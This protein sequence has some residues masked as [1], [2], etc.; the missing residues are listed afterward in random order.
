V[1]LGEQQ[2]Q[3]L[4][5]ISETEEPTLFAEPA[6]STVEQFRRETGRRL[7]NYLIVIMCIGG[8]IVVWL[9]GSG[10]GV[11]DA[12]V[13]STILP[14]A[15]AQSVFASPAQVGIMSVIAMITAFWIAIRRRASRL[16]VQI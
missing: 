16:H 10:R 4:E 6:T 12:S 2:T 3:S 13:L 14:K 7:G 9:Y 5:L 8:M 11:F 1:G 15:A